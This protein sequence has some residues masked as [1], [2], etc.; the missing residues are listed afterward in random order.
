MNVSEK[1]EHEKKIIREMIN[2]YELH[3]KNEEVTKEMEHL[4]KYALERLDYCPNIETKTFCSRCKSKC[5]TNEMQEKIRR[6][7]RF[8][9]LRMMKTHPLLVMK[10]LL[11]R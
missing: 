2:C 1:R 6:V 4:L 7:M 10:H 11:I 8:S 5:Y 9:G 3:H